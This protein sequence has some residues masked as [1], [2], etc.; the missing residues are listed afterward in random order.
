MDW[1]VYV[2]D[3]VDWMVWCGLGFEFGG[4]GLGLVV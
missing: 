1:V 3:F 4:L 2:L